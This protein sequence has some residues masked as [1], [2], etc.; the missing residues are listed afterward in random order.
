MRPFALTASH[1]SP[2]YNLRTKERTPDFRNLESV[3]I[4]QK[5]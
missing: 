1:A 2:L 3:Q 4:K 5:K